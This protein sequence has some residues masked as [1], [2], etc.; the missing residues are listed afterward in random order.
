MLSCSS[1]GG[2]GKGRLQSLAFIFPVLTEDMPKHR[3]CILNTRILPESQKLHYHL[4]T[5]QKHFSTDT[6]NTAVSEL[7][8]VNWNNSYFILGK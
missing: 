8:S 5:S 6:S 3:T 7:L 1:T 2:H 4:F